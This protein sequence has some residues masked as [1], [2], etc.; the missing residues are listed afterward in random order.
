MAINPET[1]YPGKIAPSTPDY[2]YGA[3]RNITVPGDGTGTPWEAALVNDLFGFQQAL[4]SEAGLVPTSSPEKV[5]AS[6]YLDAINAVANAPAQQSLGATVFP[7]SPLHSVQDGQTVPSGAG[8]VRDASIQKVFALSKIASGV[9]SAYSPSTRRITLGGSIV[10]LLDE[11]P[12]RSIDIS[13]LSDTSD[14]RSTVYGYNSDVHVYPDFTPRVNLLP[15]DDVTVFRGGGKVLTQDPFGNE[16]VFDVNLARNG[17]LFT[18]SQLIN[19]SIKTGD[20]LTVGFLGDSITDGSDSTGW[21]SNPW[22]GSNLTSTNYD[23][24]VVGAPNAWVSRFK[25]EINRFVLPGNAAIKTANASKSGQK[26][27]DG[28]AYRNFDYG[29]FQNA[30]YGN[31]APGVLY[32]SMGVNDN[33]SLTNLAAFETYLDEFEK[34]I[35][36]AW[37]Y[38]CAVGVVTVSNMTLALNTLENGLKKRLGEAFRN[39]EFLD[40]TTELYET[41]QGLLSPNQSD[42][43]GV[44]GTLDLT[45]PK[46]DGHS[47]MGATMVRRVLPDMVMDR[48]VNGAIRSSNCLV[49]TVTNT[50]IA[51]TLIAA[52]PY[53]SRYGAFA[54][55]NTSEDFNCF[56]T[57]Y[58]K[59]PENTATFT[60][61]ELPSGAQVS[62][63]VRQF[64]R[65]G[66][67]DYITKTLTVLT[68]VENIVTLT[69]VKAG[70]NQVNIAVQSVS[71]DFIL[72]FVFIAPTALY[73]DAKTHQLVVSDGTVRAPI[74]GADSLV[75]GPNKAICVT[76]KPPTDN[77]IGD[78]STTYGARI[79]SRGDKGVAFAYDPNTGDGVLL[80]IVAGAASLYAITADAKGALLD[81]LTGDFSGNVEL[82]VTKTPTGITATLLNADGSVRDASAGPLA[83]RIG[84]LIYH[85]NFTGS[86]ITQWFELSAGIA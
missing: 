21:V 22:D 71:G 75:S 85:A 83:G 15:T 41:M 11:V 1:Q 26:L 53:L 70:F 20:A 61:P 25:S 48:Q 77:N 8:A 69:G 79:Y 7:T 30:A 12:D 76:R 72:P 13:R 23:H 84:G 63:S 46:D 52:P 6:Q 32:I 65:S 56:Y 16:H 39:V 55:I 9:V 73:D 24:D 10:K 64:T 60:F 42:F 43:F 34:L 40:V 50:V 35:R 47:M 19:Q 67:S 38:G 18:P 82:S 31:T 17:S 2:P 66:N 68:G 5:G 81:T 62:I 36:K 49:K 4:L 28:W 44:G 57:L 78:F 74:F 80:E 14:N 37:G 45:H 54:G 33:S 86:D 51:P 59:D 27:F 3:A 58:C 29:F